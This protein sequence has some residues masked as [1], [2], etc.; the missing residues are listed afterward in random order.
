[1]KGV[2]LFVAGK[3]L[4]HKTLTMTERY[5]HLAPGTLEQAF[6]AVEDFRN[7]G[8]SANKTDNGSVGGE[9]ASESSPKTISASSTSES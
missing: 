3:A 9:D 1:M 4:G 2:P 5:S 6:Q 8:A 7:S